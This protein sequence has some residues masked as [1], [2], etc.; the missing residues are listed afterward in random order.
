[1][2]Q[3]SLML[4]AVAL[5]MSMFSCVVAYQVKIKHKLEHM[6]TTPVEN[7][8]WGSTEWP[9]ATEAPKVAEVPKVQGVVKQADTKIQITA[10]TY[11]EAIKKAKE[12]NKT[13]FAFFDASWCSACRRM[14]AE[15]LSDAKVKEAMKDHIFV[16][17]NIDRNRDLVRKYNLAAIPAYMILDKNEKQ[18]KSDKGFKDP[19]EFVK[20]LQ[21]S[22]VSK[23]SIRAKPKL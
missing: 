11:K 22:A 13:V 23:T 1:M 18:L 7:W 5:I 14:E 19:D 8:Q 9:V 16:I 3:K 10:D 4:V 6:A 2:N 17:V 12:D 15:T 21:I 20:W